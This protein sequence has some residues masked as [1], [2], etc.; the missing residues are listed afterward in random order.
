[1]PPNLGSDDLAPFSATRRSA[2][3]PTPLSARHGLMR[4]GRALSARQR[5][6]TSI[7]THASHGAT[8]FWLFCRAGAWSRPDG[9]VCFA[10]LVKAVQQKGPPPRQTQHQEGGP[11]GG[12]GLSER[13]RPRS[14]HAQNRGCASNDLAGRAPYSCWNTSASMPSGP[15]MSTER[16]RPNTASTHST[17]S[18]CTVNPA[19][20]A[21]LATASTSS[22]M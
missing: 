16:T 8:D 12:G 21:F 3:A 13:M 14:S 5:Q 4:H 18:P 19:S 2:Q 11:M 6:V 7:S 1:M 10:G 15:S 20:A 17:G 22:T 9:T